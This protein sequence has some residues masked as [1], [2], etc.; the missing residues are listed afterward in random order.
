MAPERSIYKDLGI[1][2]ADDDRWKTYWLA[3]GCFVELFARAERI[4]ALL[5]KMYAGTTS[6]VV[7]TV[8]SG[9]R[10]EEAMRQIRRLAEM[11]SADTTTEERAQLKRVFDQLSNI[12]DARNAI[13]HYGS[14]GDFDVRGTLTITS[15]KRSTTTF[16]VSKRILDAMTLDTFQIVMQLTAHMALRDAKTSRFSLSIS[17]TA[18]YVALWGLKQPWRYTHQPQPIPRGK[19]AASRPPPKR[20]PKL[21]R[22]PE[23]SPA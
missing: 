13:L 7:Q 5:L 4:I 22:R 1:D 20:H 12:N 6:E 2:G 3:L 15:R 11:A 16:Q 8:F 21:P 17:E 23:S 9:V 14:N 18:A 10:M 19:K